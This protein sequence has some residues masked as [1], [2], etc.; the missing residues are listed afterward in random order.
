[1]NKGLWALAVLGVA[2][3]VAHHRL[4]AQDRPAVPIV[5]RAS[6]PAGGP[7]PADA[8]G[9]SDAV[10]PADAVE[11]PKG[12]ETSELRPRPVTQMTV[13][14]MRQLLKKRQEE[15]IDRLDRRE[16]ESRVQDVLKAEALKKASERLDAI[17]RELLII[18]REN[19]G[20]PVG[21]RAE[22]AVRALATDPQHVPNLPPGAAVLP[23]GNDFTSDLDLSAPK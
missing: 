14:E 5:E 12:D 20:S 19:H 23:G 4:T 8:V 9:P 2:A 1:M 11:R 17:S 7:A 6:A 16:L 18:A 15:A 21:K 3:G 22:W 13:I 10:G